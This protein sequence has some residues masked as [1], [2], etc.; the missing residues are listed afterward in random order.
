MGIYIALTFLVCITAYFVRMGAGKGTRQDGVNKGLAA[1]VFLFLFLVSAMRIAVGNDY[2]KY[3]SNFL[4]IAQDRHVSSEMGFNAIVRLIQYFAGYDHYIPIFACFSFV[5]V[6]FLVLALY[7]QSKILWLSLL[8]TLSM[9]YY[10]NSLNSVRYYLALFVAL[11]AME[12]VLEKQDV[13]FLLLILG[14]ALFHKSVLVVIPI[15][16]FARLPYRKWFPALYA[17]GALS[18]LFGKEIYRYVIFRFYPFYENSAFDRGDISWIN[19]IKGAAVLLFA[20]LY[21]KDAI[22]GSREGRFYFRLNLLA[23]ILYSCGTYIPEISRIGYY[24]NISCVLLVPHV[25]SCMKDAKQR[26]IWTA[27]ICIACAGYFV[28]YLKQAYATDIRILPY[29]NW[30]LN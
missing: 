7:R 6:L 28:L 27:L 5:T 25:L 19:L 12:Y 17:G 26:K 16:L 10:F 15:Y 11:F 18:L 24:L 29:L 3:R 23:L 30:I 14:A 9:G 8:M 22:A 20:A 13:R 4:L 1:L 21:Y 2:W